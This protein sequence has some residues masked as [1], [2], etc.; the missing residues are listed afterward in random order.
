MKTILE[1][2]SF[3]PVLVKYKKKANYVAMENYLG[4]IVG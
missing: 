2:F 3:I 4:S 1:G